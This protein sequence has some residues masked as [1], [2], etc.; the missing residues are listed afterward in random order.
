MIGRVAVSEIRPLEKLSP[1]S[2]ARDS[3][4]SVKM[5]APVEK[6]RDPE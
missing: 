1:L 2:R 6:P 5:Y 4:R 3:V